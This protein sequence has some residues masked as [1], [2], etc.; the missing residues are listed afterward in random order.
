[1]NVFDK[2]KLGALPYRE[3]EL[4]NYALNYDHLHQAVGWSPPIGIETG[5]DLIL[6]DILAKENEDEK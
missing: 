1:M 4:W 3:N 6:Q 2:L 5:I